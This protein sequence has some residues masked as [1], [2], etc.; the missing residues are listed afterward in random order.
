VSSSVLPP[1][2]PGMLRATQD[3][4]MRYPLPCVWRGTP[5]EPEATIHLSF[6]HSL[7][8]PN[9]CRSLSITSFELSGDIHVGSGEGC[10]CP[11]GD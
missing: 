8:R 9:A 6:A 11:C 2:T 7:P 10:S 4:G 5:R 1:L 3:R